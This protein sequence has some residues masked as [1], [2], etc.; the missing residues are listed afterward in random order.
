M[1]TLLEYIRKNKALFVKLSDFFFSYAIYLAVAIFGAVWAL[2]T[3][4]MDAYQASDAI[5]ANVWQ[6]SALLAVFLLL[7]VA[8]SKA[9]EWVGEWLNPLKSSDARHAAAAKS[10]R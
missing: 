1:K 4:G 6:L 10:R 8:F 2:V 9:V 7:V 3:V 5:N